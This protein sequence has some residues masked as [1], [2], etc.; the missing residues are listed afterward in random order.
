MVNCKQAL[1]AHQSWRSAP[2]PRTTARQETDREDQRG[3]RAREGRRAQ[4]SRPR[5]AKGRQLRA[6][7]DFRGGVPA[8]PGPGEAQPGQVKRK[9]M[10][11]AGRRQEKTRPGKRCVEKAS[12][13]LVSGPGI[14]GSGDTCGPRGAP[15]PCRTGTWPR[16]LRFLRELPYDARPR[17]FWRDGGDGQGFYQVEAPA[18]RRALE[19][20]GGVSENDT[21]AILPRPRRH[22]VSDGVCPPS[23]RKHGPGPAGTAFAPFESLSRGQA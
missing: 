4:L 23:G 2:T 9:T 22:R 6:P 21:R 17:C 13:S 20:V 14:P 19:G 18:A 5:Q 7:C 12:P 1:S 11:R 3:D 8:R 15:A 10:A 16:D